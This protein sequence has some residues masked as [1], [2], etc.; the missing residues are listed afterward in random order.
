M[1]S[2]HT[3]ILRLLVDDES[4]HQLSGVLQTVT[5]LQTFA[6]RDGQALL[7]LLAH[8]PMRTPVN[9]PLRPGIPGAPFDSSDHEVKDEN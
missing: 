9:A 8:L 4:P 3:I 6:F 5:D 1:R 2:I 7:H